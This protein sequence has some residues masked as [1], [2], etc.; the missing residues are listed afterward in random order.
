MT[1]IRIDNPRVLSAV[2]AVAWLVALASCQAPPAGTG[3]PAAPAEGNPPAPGFDQVGSDRRAVEIADSVMERLGGRASWDATRIL[4]WRFFGKRRHLWDKGSGDLRF[5]EGGLTVLMNLNT[6]QGRAWR[7]GTAVGDPDSLASQLDHAYSAW[8]NDSYWLI[9]PYKL[10]DSGVTLKY[11]GEGMTEQGVSAHVLEL[12]FKDVGLT[13]H[14][15]YRVWVGAEDNLV[16]QWSFY[17]KADDLE[18]AFVLPW[19]GWR[20]YGRIWLADDFGRSR[21]SEVAVYEELPASVFTSPGPVSLPPP[22]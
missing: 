4:T 21:H 16:R 6:R 10:K 19:A 14:N 13:P 18:P 15:R 20:R 3:Q 7:D 22:D 5:E 12:T 17:A 9:M 2:L 8:I 11:Q 1:Q